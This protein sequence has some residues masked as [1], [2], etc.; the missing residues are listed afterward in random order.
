LEKAISDFLQAA[1]TYCLRNEYDPEKAE[2]DLIVHP[3]HYLCWG[4]RVKGT[5]EL[6]KLTTEILVDISKESTLFDETSGAI[7]L[8]DTKKNKEKGIME[9]TY[10]YLFRHRG[11][12]YC[13][14]D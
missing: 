4:H 1:G 6:V 11:K 3:T 8:G 2:F 5:K 13:S 9:S 10:I 14:Y 12:W 7:F